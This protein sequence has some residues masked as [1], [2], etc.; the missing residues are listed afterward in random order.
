MC[1][2]L[3]RDVLCGDANSIRKAQLNAAN[4]VM[5][6]SVVLFPTTNSAPFSS[7]HCLNKCNLQVLPSTIKQDVVWFPNSGIRNIHGRVG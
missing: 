7:V 3:W 2:F 6:A 1:L 5:W 4:Y